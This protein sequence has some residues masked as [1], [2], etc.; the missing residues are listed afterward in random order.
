MVNRKTAKWI[1][2]SHRYLGIFLGVQFL[3][4]TI[5]GIYFS[6]TDIDEI[7][8]DHYKKSEVPL[9]GFKNLL[10]TDSLD[11]SHPITTMNLLDI[12]GDPYYWVNDSALYQA[13]TGA[14]RSGISEEEAL[15]VAK[16]YMLPELEVSGIVRVDSVGPHH[17]Y[18]GRPLPAYEISY[19]SPENLKAYVAVRNGDFQ[20]VRHRSWRWFDFLWMTHTM[21]YQTRDDFN[22]TLLRS[23]S[24]LGL[25]TVL[26]GFLLWFISSPT[27]RRWWRK[28]S[29]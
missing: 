7:H 12:A 6:W 9:I 8:G 1:R 21:D 15:E 10:G 11:L 16:K 13:R 5:S 4:W 2:K 14:P 26:S 17:E 18:R 3:M 27:V 24:L 25:I 20:T 29:L 28:I 19:R 22:T 23:F